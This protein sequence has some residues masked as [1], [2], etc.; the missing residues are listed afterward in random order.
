MKLGFQKFLGEYVNITPMNWKILFG[1]KEKSNNSIDEEEEE[2]EEEEEEG[3]YLQLLIPPRV[4][5]L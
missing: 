3:K 4:H 1:S 2:K 5:L